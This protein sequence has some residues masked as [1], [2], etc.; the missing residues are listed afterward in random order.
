MRQPLNR[1]RSLLAALALGAA[2]LTAQPAFAGQPVPFKALVSGTI[3]DGVVSG[4]GIVSQL[5]FSGYGGTAVVSSSDPN[6]GVLNVNL[7]VTLTAA[8]G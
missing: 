3:S 1:V 7:V 2:A 6:T 4:S 5:G 8:S